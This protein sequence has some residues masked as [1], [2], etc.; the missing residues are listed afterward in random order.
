MGKID[1]LLLQYL[2]MRL[3]SA[4]LTV[5][6]VRLAS[7][8]IRPASGRFALEDVPLKASFRVLRRRAAEPNPLVRYFFVRIRAIRADTA[9]PERAELSVHA[10]PDTMCKLSGCSS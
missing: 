8:R 4:R 5:A 7:R 1:R 10:P 2:P 6:A 9:R 3:A